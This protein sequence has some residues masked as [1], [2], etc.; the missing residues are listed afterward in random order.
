M[1]KELHK[2]IQF[3]QIILFLNEITIEKI[4]IEM[5]QFWFITGFIRN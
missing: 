3:N 1:H 2:V 5:H 4:L